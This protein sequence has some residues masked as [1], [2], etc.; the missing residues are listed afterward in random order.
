[1]NGEPCLWAEFGTGDLAVAAAHYLRE[2]G[3]S[4]LNAFGPYPLL[5]L[6]T[7]LQLPRPWPLPV[8][9]FVGACLGG[10]LAFTI[11][12]WTAA[13]DYP[14]NVGGRP[15]NS[16]VADIPIVFESSVLG[17]AVSG[18]F[19][20]LVSC[21]MPRLSHPLETL[22]GFERTAVDRFWLGVSDPSAIE[23]AQ[24]AQALQRIG[25]LRVQRWPGRQ[26]H[27]P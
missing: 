19:A 14:L 22:P 26:T 6:E 5:E 18:F 17:A 8:L 12:W 7:A 13:V 3:F 2:R 1:M 23:D 25:A 16:L 20:L 10:S 15:L 9:V 21:G 11:M 4:R 27:E 24:L